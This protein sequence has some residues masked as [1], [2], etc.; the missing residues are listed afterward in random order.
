MRVTFITNIRSPYRKLQIENIQKRSGHKISVVY[1]DKNYLGRQWEVKG[2]KN[3]E[4]KIFSFFS[5]SKNKK[6]IFRI[7]KENDVVFL[8]GYYKIQY[9]ILAIV[10]KIHKVPYVLLF[11][12]IDPNK[13]SVRDNPLKFLLKKAVISNSTM[14]YG[15]G[16]VSRELFTKKFKV[17]S[18]KIVNQY[19]SI[20][21][22]KITELKK[23][24]EKIRKTLRDKFKISNDSKVIIYSG[25]LIERKN[26]K[27]II[28]AVKK[29]NNPKEFTLLIL[30]DGI[31]KNNLMNFAKENGIK[32]IITGFIKNQDEL[33]KHYFIGDLFIL[34][35]HDEPWGLVVNEAMAA[36]L[37]I[38]LSEN[39]GSSL[40]LINN[41]GFIF[42]T[43]NIED[44]ASKIN[45]INENNLYTD[46]GLN[47]SSIIKNWTFDHSSSSYLK[48]LKHIN[49]NA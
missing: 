28:S 24:K 45:Y 20:D 19:L 36:G 21:N 7:P 44:L 22:D 17:D 43:H 9:I 38:I 31:E 49:N 30:G 3:I 48:I 12:G 47:S 35:S 18:T 2:L 4:E 16:K 6:S 41:N 39:C 26:I 10:C 5:N 37:P 33:F 14:I 40:D 32:V 34:P 29:L 23:D 15:N 25:R 27:N 42:E 11:D 46:F 13:V 8:G 1:T